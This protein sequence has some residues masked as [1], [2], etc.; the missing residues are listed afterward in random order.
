MFLFPQ[1]E[2]FSII[3]SV[4]ENSVN[5]P[6]H[7][8]YRTSEPA[9]IGERMQQELGV[10]GPAEECR[11]RLEELR[12]MGLA[13]PVIAPLPVG[14]LKASYERTIRALAP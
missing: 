8:A 13:K 5:V 9:V 7:N 10:V 4:S 14:D 2:V 11:A 12:K 6:R 1:P 3:P